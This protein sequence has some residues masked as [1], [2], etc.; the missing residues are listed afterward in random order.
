LSQINAAESGGTYRALGRWLEDMMTGSEAVVL[1]FIVAA[2]AI[3]GTTLA[4]LSS[5][6]R[7]R[8]RRLAANDEAH[9]SVAKRA[10]AWQPRHS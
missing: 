5:D 8:S 1:G 4:W 3:F 2:F 6:V 7:R 10:H 9:P